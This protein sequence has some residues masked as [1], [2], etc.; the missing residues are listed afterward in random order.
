MPKSVNLHTNLAHLLDTCLAEQKATDGFEKAE[1]KEGM[2]FAK[3]WMGTLLVFTA[4][5]SWA[6][7]KFYIMLTFPCNGQ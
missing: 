1:T 3:A 4:L 6:L 5:A 2:I 7:D